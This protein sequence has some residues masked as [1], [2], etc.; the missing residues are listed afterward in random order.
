MAVYAPR[1]KAGA[2]VAP[3]AVAMVAD[4]AKKQ[5]GGIPVVHDAITKSPAIQPGEG[6]RAIDTFREHYIADDRW[7]QAKKAVR[8]HQLEDLDKGLD[9][10]AESAC[11]IWYLAGYAPEMPV[12]VAQEIVGK[13][14]AERRRLHE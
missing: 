10:F 1:R 7:I 2:R 3:H 8:R 6:A 12:R 9:Y 4:A 13:L 14:I 5:K 11:L